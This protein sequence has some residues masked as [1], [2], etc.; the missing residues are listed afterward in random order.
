[1]ATANT[2]GTNLVDMVRFLRGQREAARALLPA[3]LHHYLDEQ[4]NVAAS[5]PEEDMIGLVRALAKLLPSAGEDPLVRIGR[6][7]ARMHLQGTYEHL[8]AD[9]RPAALPVRALA[10]WRS[11]HDTGEFRLAVEEDHAEA[12]LAGYGFPS[13][14][15][16]TM[17]GAYLLELFELAGVKAPRV[18]ELSCCRK[19]APECRWRIEWPEPAAGQALPG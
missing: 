12:R 1:V 9:A 5:Y 19:G 4:L 11:M 3:R 7:N 16:C 13:A 2:K 17:L 8:I 15:M 6:L 18:A 10:L 14:E